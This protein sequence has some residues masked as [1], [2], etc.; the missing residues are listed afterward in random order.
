MIPYQYH[1]R[2]Q[3]RKRYLQ[4]PYTSIFEFLSK[5]FHLNRLPFSYVWSAVN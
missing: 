5:L 2:A 1:S 4:D 3:I